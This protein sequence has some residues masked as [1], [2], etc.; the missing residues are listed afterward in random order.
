MP[1]GI[2]VIE[3]KKYILDQ[4]GL[5]SLD[6]KGYHSD[7][8]DLVADTT[9]FDSVN[10]ETPETFAINPDKRSILGTPVF[11]DMRLSLGE[12]SI[13]LDAVM[14]DIAQSKNIVTT[15]INGR[16]G[17]IKEYI[18]DGDYQIDI[19]LVLT[20]PD[21]NYP[22][23]QVRVMRTLLTATEALEVVSPIL[24]LFE[25]HNLVVQDYKILSPAG[26]INTQ[27]IEITCLSDTPIELVEDDQTV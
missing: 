18:S 7:G 26:F 21:G 17:T 14:F 24:Q 5:K 16:A 11:S 9:A 13:Y 10:A 23:D 20:S 2:G 27:P 15:A 19:K 3:S 4:W 12:T 25:I 22:E 8:K 1:F 6:I